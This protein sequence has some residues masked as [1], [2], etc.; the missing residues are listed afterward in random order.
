MKIRSFVSL[1]SLLTMIFTLSGCWEEKKEDA[2]AISFEL[3]PIEVTNYSETPKEVYPL[4]IS[5]S[6]PAAPI[7]AVNQ[8]VTQG[9]TLEPAL[10][11]KW[12][13]HTDT[14]LSFKPEQDWPTGQ[15][16]QIKID[17]K[18]LNPQ[19][20]Y[21]KALQNVQTITTPTFRAEITEQQFYQDPS[22]A[23]IRHAI[24]GV[25]FTHPVDRQ[26]FENAIQVN[27]VR[28]NSDGTQHI[29][30]PLHFKVRYA[31][32][33]TAAW[34]QS[35]S[36]NL[37]QSD[38]QYIE[39]KI[40]KNLTALLGQ[41]PLENELVADVKVPTKFS[42][43]FST[44]ILIAQNEK[45]E[46]EQILHLNFTHLVK[47]SEV[48]KHVSA[49]L[50]P[51]FAP[52]NSTYW[53]YSQIT[54]EVVDKARQVTL[55]RLPT[56]TA[57]A[58]GQS[59][60]LAI[61]AK[62]CL[63][64][65]VDNKISALGGYQFKTPLGD[66]ICAPEYPKHVSFVGKGSILSSVGDKKVTIS[67]RNF[68]EIKLEVGRIQEEQLRH[69][70]SLNQGDF[71]HPNLGELKIDHIADFTTKT[72]KINNKRP[73][74]PNYFGIDLTTIMKQR[75]K[76]TGVYWLKVSGETNTAQN[77]LRDTSQYED[78]RNDANNQ[79]SDYRLVVLTD[80]GIIAKKAIDG[81]Q[82]VFVQ[83]ISTGEAV[84]GASVSVIS[85]NGSIIKTDFSDENGVVHFSSLDHFKQELAPVMY[86]VSIEDQLSFLPIDKF[87]RSLDY[88]RFDVGGIY[89]DQDMAS[90]KSY[91]FND[92]GI[93]RPNETIH[94]GMITKS[95]DWKVALNNVPLQFI[96]T[97]PSER[98]MLK[99]TIRLDKSG[100]NS[101]SFTLPENAETGEWFAQL[102]V[103]E[104]TNQKEVG[105]MTF[106][107]QEFQPDSLKIHTTFNQPV[108]EGW[109]APQDLVATV[110]LSNLFG[111]PAQHRRVNAELALYPVL[112]KFSQYEHYQ[113]FDNQRNK[114]AIL[115]ET[116]LSEQ[117]TDKEGKAT[118]PIDLSQYAENT[119]QMLFFT[120]DGFENDSG[121]AVST[122]KSVMVSAQPWLV[123]YRS[124]VDLAYLKPHIPSNIHLIAVN[125][126]LQQVAVD[127]L[128][129]T[130]FERKYVSVLTQQASGAY[131]YESKLIENEIEQRSIQLAQSGLNFDLNTEKS[132][133][134]VLV[135]SNEYD[136]EVNRIHYTVIG[137]KNLMVA[138]DK[139]TELKL[140]LNKKQFQPNEEIEIAIQAPYTGSG[141]I[142]IERDR[143][144]AHKWFKATTN[145]SVQ[146][147][148]LPANF[149]GNG[150]INVQFSRDIH[151]NDIFTSPLSY[152]IAP[153]TVN[154][155]NRRLDLSLTGPKHVKSGEVIEFK[156]QSNKP[157]KAIIFAVN[158]GILQVA[159]YKFNDPLTFFFPKNA[160]QVQTSQ[161]LD[162]ILPEFSKV[163]QF[164]QTGGD[165]DMEMDIA[166]KMAMANTNPFKR[167]TDKPVAYW[168]NII[169]VEGEKTVTYQ[170]PEAFNGKL[171]V[172]AIAVSQTGNQVGH[173]ETATTVRNDLVLSPTVPLTLTP[174]DQSD[175]SVTIAN[176]T[177]K[178]QKVSLNVS[179]APQLSLVGETEKTIEI[180]PMSEGIVHFA[181]NATEQLG[182]SSIRFTASYKNN[183][184]QMVQVVRHVN[185]SVRPIMPKQF[186]TQLGKV[187]AGKHVESKLPMILFP[188]YRQQSA[189]FSPAPLVLAQGV[190]AYL[191]Q[192]DNYCT[193][194]M[195]SAAIPTL[196]FANNPAY[197]PLLKA[198]TNTTNSLTQSSEQTIRQAL[199][200][201][202][203]LLPNR[204][205]EEGYY[206]VWNNIEQ[207]DLFLTAY[208]AHFLIE[209]QQRNI[210][211]PQAWFGQDGL[212][213]T[214][215]SALEAQS[216]PQ[217]GDSI[218]ELRQRAYSAYLLTRLGQVPSNALMTIRTQLEQN[219]SAQDWQSDTLAAWLAAAYH[220][221][222]QENEANQLIEYSVKQLS[223]PRPEQWLYRDYSDPLIQDS[224]MLYVIA[225]YF[226]TR[227]THV[228]D[229][230][231]TRITQDLN[232]QRYNTLSSAM[233]LLALDAY[234]Q[235]HQAALSS[236]QI[237]QNGQD[238]S[239]HNSL[240][241]FVDLNKETADVTFVNKG[242]QPAWYVLNQ[243]GYPEKAPDKA[244]TNGLEI[245]RT[246]TDKEGNK[247]GSVKLGDRIYVT[248]NVRSTTDYL[249]DVIITDLYPAGFEVIWQAEVE[250]GSNDSW[251]PQ[252][253]EIREDRILNYGSVE[254]TLQ[255]LK[256]QLK[257][258][259]VG[260]FHIPPV[261]A[262][263]MYDR[264]IKSYSASEGKITV[265]K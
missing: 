98:T 116:S 60:K 263:S 195:I 259:N 36:V 175:V 37:A 232:Q 204:Q 256:Y 210:T 161:I 239:Q 212:F 45:H 130:L 135:L 68:D 16:Y 83:S 27:L 85:R 150:Y 148:T 264:S 88:S 202:F 163:M 44:G 151:S 231:L 65:Y 185:L 74:E 127:N 33:D 53:R 129:A 246:Y 227:L 174:G 214:T 166:M 87:D 257:A 94:T 35:D 17:P 100:F 262:E 218:S 19:H 20:T 238:V 138:M 25:S 96:I 18:I 244:Y 194:Q 29:I 48:E 86:I 200:K 196:L 31:N 103:G 179:V 51:E 176:N 223:T 82:M 261:Y 143:V 22:Q 107:V 102:L 162:L 229:N 147:I 10:K 43:G 92:R 167:K 47:G 226:P 186:V 115:Y 52:D 108:I 192:Y 153:F 81:S 69:L 106:Q 251:S 209:A 237:Q 26:K 142:T 220:R 171:K 90:L 260:T 109:I 165:T 8:E 236:L 71:Q 217:E 89:A 95:Q 173:A 120:A 159:N 191:T 124:E 199:E 184:Q 49:Y 84:E 136:Q 99:Q 79:F 67:A 57:Y 101:V 215:I 6:G 24:I 46:A 80:L 172:M 50:L 117:I 145:T 72:Y 93:Y 2:N 15:T 178:T 157:S 12:F 3:N 155:D 131:K 248:I 75:S 76:P 141:L 38:N 169:E 128:K 203:T 104:K 188:Q 233:V 139:N 63:Y 64:L 9:I 197:Q 113:F 193:E 187:D 77:H 134:F 118:F 211:L 30:S 234:A 156:L 216:M 149:E 219:F 122:V 110:Q 32:N 152:G 137:N 249:S 170:V 254:G 250:S 255:T 225:R 70:I 11:G 183:Q 62:R 245:H 265:T 146:R 154:V 258:I 121:R 168:S 180:A 205:T 114:S 42:L 158:E 177:D 208:V 123:G 55:T 224:T 66:L 242:T 222:K 241:R 119:A 14:T 164:A 97:S 58:N 21:V 132:G 221:L 61:P 213:N 4:V 228:G 206:G 112:P 54:Q 207:G 34:I 41:N 111:T 190:S 56:E 1:F 230:A 105:S 133:D 40:T 182:A 181:I 140:R 39:T 7:S 28:K 59:F 23:H 252:H 253:T 160:L 73:Q 247:L 13:W 91:L 5:F 198:L 144:Y 78:W 126:T 125:P 189:L 243:E 235:Q 201:V 240:F